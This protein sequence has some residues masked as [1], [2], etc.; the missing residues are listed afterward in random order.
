[1]TKEEMNRTKEWAESYCK[2]YERPY[3]SMGNA[4]RCY[5]HAISEIERLQSALKD[6]QGHSGKTLLADCCVNK[7]CTPHFADGEQVAVCAYQ[8]GVFDGYATLAAIA[9]DALVN[10]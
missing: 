9:E 1:M 3:Y 6:I 5:L 4:A 8:A 7:S 10:V 2:D